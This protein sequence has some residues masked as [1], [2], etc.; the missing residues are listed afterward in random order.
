MIKTPIDI[1]ENVPETISGDV[2][3]K[4]ETL[5][6]YRRR[7]GSAALAVEMV[8][9]KDGTAWY[10]LKTYISADEKFH[11]LHRIFWA[12]LGYSAEQMEGMELLD[13]SKYSEMKTYLMINIEHNGP[14]TNVKKWY[15]KQ[16]NNYIPVPWHWSDSEKFGGVP[17]EA[18][19]A[20]KQ[21]SDAPETY[22]VK[23]QAS[24][25]K[26]AANGSRLT[27]QNIDLSWVTDEN[28]V[29]ELMSRGYGIT[30]P[31]A[32]P[33]AK[34]EAKPKPALPKAA[35]FEGYDF[36]TDDLDFA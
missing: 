5:T 12:A 14:Y 31:A 15:P 18:K 25:A 20:P 16:K 4:I 27:P 11:W 23:T 19:P 33:K 35:T 13:P 26:Q 3:A 7:D 9:T 8:V 34:P 21:P 24:P 28:L 29:A 1:T 36:G 2:C 17:Y 32:K 30:A 6:Q 10:N 22:V